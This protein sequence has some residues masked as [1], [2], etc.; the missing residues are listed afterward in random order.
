MKRSLISFNEK[1]RPGLVKAILLIILGLF[2]VGAPAWPALA[3]P[4]GVPAGV[5]RQ[6][7]VPLA[8]VRTWEHM[9]AV[10]AVTAM[11]GGLAPAAVVV[12]FRPTVNAATYQ[13]HKAKAA[14]LGGAARVKA[15]R[16]AAPSP[17]PPKIKG[18][19]FEGVNSVTAGNFRPP[20]THG[21]VGLN[22]FVEVTNSHLDIY[23]KSNH[24]KVRGLSLDKF[25]GYFLSIMF[26]PQVV[27]DQAADR[28]I[29]SADTFANNNTAGQH[30][31]LA[32]S[33]TSDPRGAYYIY[34]IPVSDGVQFWDYPH[35]G[36]DQNSI[37]ITANM[38]ES[39]GEGAFVDGRLLVI[40]KA[41]AYNGLPLTTTLFTDLVGSI[42]APIVLDDNPSTFLVSAPVPAPPATEN[43]IT[44]YTLTYPG[45]VPSLATSAITV[46]PFGLPPSAAQNTNV[47]A[48]LDTLDCRFVNFS[49]QVGDSL[50]QVHTI[51]DGSGF[52]RPRYY[53]FDTA[54]GTVAA[55]GIFSRSAT[56]YD[57]N[58][59][60][61]ANANRDVFVTWTATDPVK[62]ANAEVR[63]SG[64]QSTDPI[65]G[66]ASPGVKL[67]GS[68]SYYNPS[69]L[70]DGGVLLTERWGDYSA[71]SID[72]ADPTKAWVVNERNSS[73][74]RWAS[75]I[76]RIGY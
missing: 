29:I 56:S 2:L 13:E 70:P 35:L 60:I 22:H 63:F 4:P 68:S 74:I 51:A 44:L 66:I 72:P 16:A 3:A 67:A 53:E 36:V 73:K 71:V 76:G 24:S 9:A 7:V 49:T 5:A 43:Q 41:L 54:T 27:Y 48:F 25:F 46:D 31:W 12:P 26:D 15:P 19:N 75:R 37:L 47:K 50:F 55:S 30:N 39:A 69:G 57:F 61:A 10:E 21:A 42:A 28:W 23:K 14:A 20:D 64:R 65:P 33:Q 32:V 11:P 1:G 34:A 40:P 18:Q 45:G 17:V 52:A 59:S 8:Q 6:Q 38:F 58:A 62:K